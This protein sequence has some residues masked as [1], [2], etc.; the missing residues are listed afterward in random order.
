MD[1]ALAKVSLPSLMTSMVRS[2]A[3]VSPEAGSILISLPVTD[4]AAGM[5]MPSPDSTASL[6]PLRVPS[7]LAI[8][9]RMTWVAATP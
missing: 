1:C 7:D 8:A 2:R 6:T 5:V 4:S 9:A 3:V